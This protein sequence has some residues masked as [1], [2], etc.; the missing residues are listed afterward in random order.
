MNQSDGPSDF[1]EQAIVR[2]AR[3]LGKRVA[4]FELSSGVSYSMTEP[5]M[6]SVIRRTPQDFAGSKAFNSLIAVARSDEKLTLLHSPELGSSLMFSFGTFS[7]RFDFENLLQNIFVSAWMELLL[8][9]VR[10]DSATMGER[11]L[12]NF[13]QLRRTANGLPIESLEIVG[14]E[15]F[16]IAPGSSINTP[17]GIIYPSHTDERDLAMYR[18]G[19]W[20]IAGCVLVRKREIKVE[21][22]GGAEP[23]FT[24][25]HRPNTPDFVSLLLPLAV[26]LSSENPESPVAPTLAWSTFLHPFAASVGMTKTYPSTGARSA[27]L[28]GTSNEE[29]ERWAALVHEHHHH[30]V[31][32]AARRL[33]AAIARRQDML[34][35]ILDLVMVWENLVGGRGDTTL[36]VCGSI[37]K[38]LET[39]PV[40]RA[41]MYRRLQEV[42]D[43]R[44]RI[45][46]GE[47]KPAANDREILHT[48][49]RSAV[50][51]LRYS[52]RRG[53]T[54]LSKKATER[55]LELLLT[56]P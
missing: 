21:F 2:F 47:H 14:L 26:A 38:V 52:Y 29:V 11:A 9:N 48:A 39:D 24:S 44:S 40:K 32:A 13:R 31:D 25:P 41:Q 45:V 8:R 6:S 34:D 35:S 27:F 43:L 16:R 20:P 4:T 10:V 37:A 17:W 28:T 22:K 5:V 42:Y 30:H 33:I 54:W 18:L 50:E 15:G 23:I 7:C 51:L 56:L 12:K 1:C 3:S 36:R 49:M 55:S 19:N 46:H 53:N